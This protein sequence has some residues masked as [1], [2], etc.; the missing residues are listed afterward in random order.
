M[1][2]DVHPSIM[3]VTLVIFLAMIIILNSMLYKPLLKFM[4]ERKKSI[5]NDEKKV[6]ENFDEVS[7]FNV[8]LEKIHQS[9]REEIALIKQA[10]VLD[11]KTKAGED[12]EQKKQE[13]EQQMN[14]FYAQ[15]EKDK[16]NFEQEL[17]THLAQWQEVFKNKLKTI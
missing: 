1:F 2:N 11:A 17:S 10:A 8:E 13:L 12:L 4:D 14:I 9:T 6:R 7:S 16:Q 3:L 15:L 5:D